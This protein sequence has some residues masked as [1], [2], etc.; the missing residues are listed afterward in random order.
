MERS[1]LAMRPPIGHAVS[2]PLFQSPERQWILSCSRIVE[3]DCTC[4]PRLRGENG[5][6][7]IINQWRK[8]NTE[9]RPFI[10]TRCN[11]SQAEG[12]STQPF[13]LSSRDLDLFECIMMRM[14]RELHASISPILNSLRMDVTEPI[15]A[16]LRQGIAVN[17]PRSAACSS[18]VPTMV[19]APIDRII[20]PFDWGRR[21]F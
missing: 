17:N 20:P 21:K 3:E 16:R 19:E 1:P 13:S 12:V 8:L 14:R 11:Q 5:V 15:R 7:E 4:T 10:L 18:A 6:M 9:R 2:E